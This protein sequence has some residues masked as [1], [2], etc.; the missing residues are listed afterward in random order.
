MLNE[1]WTLQQQKY[2]YPAVEFEAQTGLTGLSGS[3]TWPNG[4]CPVATMDRIRHPNIIAYTQE[5]YDEV[6]GLADALIALNPDL[7]SVRIN[8]ADPESVYHFI[9]GV[10]SRFNPSDI[11]F[12]LNDYAFNIPG[13][14]V[15][16][17]CRGDWS[18]LEPFEDWINQHVMMQYIKA[19]LGVEMRW[20]PSPSTLQHIV[21]QTGL[22][23]FV[24]SDDEYMFHFAGL[25]RDRYGLSADP[26]VTEYVPRA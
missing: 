4:M 22:N 12:Y 5:I 3:Y 11:D 23:C 20:I 8:R 21:D 18:T 15:I 13:R 14:S 16:M 6:L 24:L 10:A 26:S 25:L 1:V 9:S 19:Q 17:A 7:A 2:S